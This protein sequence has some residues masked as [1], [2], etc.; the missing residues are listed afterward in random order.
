MW[1]NKINYYGEFILYPVLIASLA[2]VTLWRSPPER[3]P[4]WLV[5]FISGVWLWTL[6]EYILH[7]Y[8]LHHVPYIRQIHQAHHDEQEALVGTPVWIRLG[9]FAVF[10]ILPLRVVADPTIAAGVTAGMM[11]GYFCFETMHHVLHHWRIEPGSY[12]Y[13]LKRRH[14]LHHYFDNTGN[15]G[16][17]NGLWD[18][19]FGTDIKLRRSVIEPRS[20][21]SF[22]DSILD[23]IEII[24]SRLEV[25]NDQLQQLLIQAGVDP[26]AHDVA[27]QLH[28]TMI[29]ELHHRAKNMLAIVSAITTQSLRSAK[30]IDAASIAIADGLHAIGVAHDLLIQESWRGASCRTLV[31]NAIM[32]FRAKELKQFSVGGADVHLAAGPAVS[33][34]LIIN[35]LCTNAVKYGPLSVPTGRVLI[36]WFVDKGERFVLQWKERDGPPVSKPGQPSFGTR[37]IE[38]GLPQQLAGEARLRFETTGLECEINVPL[39]SLQAR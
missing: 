39:S 7:R 14:M 22:L 13:Q 21:T 29:G 11:L 32:A 24:P 25:E 28:Q 6:V 15:F 37:L 17:T 38:R 30:D 33:L 5:A 20:G 16:V 18:K 8:V 31:T 36:D 23:R 27:H 9:S 1:L 26:R 34:A 4:I 2:A 12:A 3:L 10:L 19:L 35:E